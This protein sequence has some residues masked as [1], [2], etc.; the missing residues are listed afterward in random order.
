MALITE[1]LSPIPF[2]GIVGV[3]EDR[4][5]ASPSLGS[6]Y[7]DGFSLAEQKK[8]IRSAFISCEQ[9]APNVGYAQIYTPN[10]NEKLFLLGYA[11]YQDHA[12]ARGSFTL[13]DAV[14]GLPTS[15]G[16]DTLTTGNLILLS[17]H[18]QS[19]GMFMSFLPYPIKINHGLRLAHTGTLGTQMGLTIFYVVED[20]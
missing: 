11:A 2:D 15:Y 8:R 16:A 18:Y 1:S 13:Y 6:G 17:E 7:I 14:D 10:N 5:K 12:T 20:F 19:G 3:P 9:V 4:I